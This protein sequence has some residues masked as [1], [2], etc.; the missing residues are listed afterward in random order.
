MRNVG[1][2]IVGVMV[3]GAILLAFDVVWLAVVATKL[4]DESLAGLKREQPYV[5]A[6]ALFYA[7]YTVATY[8]YAVRGRGSPR[9]ATLHGAGLG[10]VAYATYELTNWAVIQ[11]WPSTIVLVDTLWGIV[12]TGCSAGLS[13]QLL[14]RLRSAD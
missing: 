4:Y 12:L 6:A 13:H 14:R 2:W 7:M 5:P 10:L 8:S 3:T 11:H 9:E 1:K